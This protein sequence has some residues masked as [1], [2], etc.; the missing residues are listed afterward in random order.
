MRRAAHHY[1]DAGTPAESPVNNK[2]DATSKPE[3]LEEWTR[4]HEA[5]GQL[6]DE[7]RSVLELVWYSGLE[8]SQIA[9]VLG[10]SVRSVQRQW[11]SAKLSL[12]KILQGVS[13]L[14][15]EEVE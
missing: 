8:Q 9:E 14:E 3:T 15:A 5:I 1:S 10:V 11:R 4:F 12:F 13:P 7:E 2:A 6:P